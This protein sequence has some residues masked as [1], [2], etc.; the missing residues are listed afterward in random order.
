MATYDLL[1]RLTLL[2]EADAKSEGSL[3][4]LGLYA[5]ADRLAVRLVPG[6]RQRQSHPRFL[7]ALAVAAHVCAEFP[8]D[9]VSPKDQVSEP[10]QVFEWYL[11]EGLVRTG[12][13]RDDL[14][15]LPGRDKATAAL[16]DGVPLSAR[17]YLKNPSVFGFHGVYRVLANDLSIHLSDHLGETGSQLLVAWEEEQDLVGFVTSRPGPGAGWRQSLKKAVEDGLTVGATARS[18]TWSG[19]SFF[20]DHLIHSRIGP[21]EGQVL[22]KALLNPRAGHRS[23]VLNFSC[24]RARDSYMA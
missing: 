4:P 8:E 17:R 10:W 18:G 20:H 3:D 19:W 13:E 9:A 11:V 12:T 1:P 22:A 6:V 7:T 21:R 24:V 15:G 16:G 23:E 2:D 14:R 5:I